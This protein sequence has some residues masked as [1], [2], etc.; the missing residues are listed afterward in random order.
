[1]E[2]IGLESLGARRRRAAARNPSACADG[3]E[4]AVPAGT[5]SQRADKPYGRVDLAAVPFVSAQGRRRARCSEHGS[6]DE[7]SNRQNSVAGS[8]ADQL[9][10]KHHSSRR[11]D[12]KHLSLK[13][14]ER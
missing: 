5:N 1:M 12:R 2:A 11:G 7:T 8:I 10:S 14:G 9:Y 13:S 4:D 6:P 3:N